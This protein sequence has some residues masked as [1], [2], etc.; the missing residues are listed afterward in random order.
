MSPDYIEIM[1]IS[2]AAPRASLKIRNQY[3]IFENIPPFFLAACAT[4]TSVIQLLFP[5]DLCHQSSLGKHSVETKNIVTQHRALASLLCTNWADFN[6][7]S[8]ELPRFEVC[9]IT[10][11]MPR[12]GVM[13]FWKSRTF[14]RPWKDRKFR[15]WALFL[16]LYSSDWLSFYKIPA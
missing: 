2:L 14:S 9:Y 13:C 10:F 7:N 3:F 1:L 5:R 15:C 11:G 6:T 4:L 8:D 16:K 12:N